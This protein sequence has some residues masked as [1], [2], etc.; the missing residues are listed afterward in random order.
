MTAGKVERI[1][2]LSVSEGPPR[3]KG[4]CFVATDESGSVVAEGIG[5]SEGEALHKLIDANYWRVCELV[6]TR[7][8]WK[9][10]RCGRR[11]GLECHHIIHRSKGRRDEPS[12]ILAI[13]PDCHRQEHGV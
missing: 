5:R 9:C 11:V 3:S 10:E 8:G 2:G 12:N 4:F 1:T 7:A 6:R 13:C